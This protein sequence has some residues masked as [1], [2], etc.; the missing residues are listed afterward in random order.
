MT[1]INLYGGPG[2][3]KSSVAAQLFYEMKKAGYKVELV[4]EY[5]KDLVYSEEFFKLKDQLM[6]FAKQHH[7]LWKLRGKVDYAIVDSPLPLS[8]VYAPD[9]MIYHYPDLSKLILSTYSQY[10]N[11]DFFLVRNLEEH[12]YQEYGRQ[13]TVEEAIDK[14]DEILEM[15]IA[16][17]IQHR[18]VSYKDACS[19]ILKRLND[20]NS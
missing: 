7:K 2:V 9:D 10:D 18:A 20:S 5:A 12:G 8:L 16:Y 14:D 19:S 17:G 4:T 3:G 15:L 6:V 13:E 11:R 1:V